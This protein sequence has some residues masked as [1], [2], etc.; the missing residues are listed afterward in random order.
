MALPYRPPPYPDE[1]IGSW[2]SRLSYLNAGAFRQLAEKHGFYRSG[3]LNL[4]R[5]LFNLSCG[6]ENFRSLIDELEIGYEDVLLN[7][8]TLPYWL[9][10]CAMS[11]A[12]GALAG[13]VHVPRVFVR[14]VIIGQLKQEFGKESD[15]SPKYCPR[16]LDED[17]KNFGE[18]YWH[19]SHQLPTVFYCPVHEVALLSK[20]IRC[21]G[22]VAPLQRTL[23]R[24]LPVSC[25]HCFKE[26]SDSSELPSASPYLKRLADVSV[27]AL[28]ITVRNWDA[29]AVRR[30]FLH[31][32]DADD[33][34]IELRTIELLQARRVKKSYVVQHT[35]HAMPPTS[36]FYFNRAL[37]SAPEYCALAAASNMTLASAALQWKVLSC[38]KDDLQS[39]EEVS[40]RKRAYKPRNRSTPSLARV[41]SLIAAIEVLA[42]SSVVE[43]TL[44]QAAIS[45]EMRI[46]TAYRL[47]RTCDEVRNKLREANRDRYITV[48]EDAAFRLRFDG[49]SL[50]V[51]KL[52]VEAGLGG[53]RAQ[54]Q[55][56]AEEVL[57]RSPA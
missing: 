4:G 26:L 29:H 11:M 55:T 54:V 14:G 22:T 38:L 52:I 15:G 25:P 32:V 3:T 39:I 13:T 56:L 19:R 27:Q 12:G 40:R 53:R 18:P 5:S 46:A 10:F 50:S 9:C 47:A 42:N 35:H 1:V 57:S 21:G 16:C 49:V 30:F 23:I 36:R 45:I 31:L 28:S 44:K 2:L 51:N 24:P 34:A 37:V 8:T 41:D 43:I 48:L 33:E 20:C 17:F 7:L 6:G